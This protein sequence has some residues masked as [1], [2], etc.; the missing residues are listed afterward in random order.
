MRVEDAQGAAADDPVL[1]RRGAG[2]HDEL[3]REVRALRDELDAR[4]PGGRTRGR[5]LEPA[6]QADD[7]NSLAARPR[8]ARA[9]LGEAR[10]RSARCRAGHASSLE[11]FFDEA[12]GMQLVIHAPFGGRINRA[13]GLAL[14][15]K[16]CRGFDFELQAAATDD[17][18]VLSLGQRAQL[19]ARRRLR[20]PR[21][22]HGRETLMQA[23]ARSPDVRD[24]L[25]LERHALARRPA[26]RGGTRVP[27]QLQRMRAA[28]LL[29]AVFP[30]AAACQ[31]NLRARARC[32][33]TR[34]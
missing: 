31:D 29:A 6:S 21:P 13:W 11:R 10:A 23:L 22:D 33:I 12:G 26:L 5:E 28:D 4:L 18:T 32:P 19:P 9:Y 34:W 1:V 14:R 30:D 16:F 3:S 27:P 8:A 20:L 7:G 2:A 17:G 25:A 15:K 24:A